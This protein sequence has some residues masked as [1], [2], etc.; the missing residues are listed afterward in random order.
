[1]ASTARDLMTA[2][3]ITVRG[4]APVLEVIHLF[5]EAQI[6]CVPVV[7]GHGNLLGLV[8]AADL[9]AALDQALD[10]DV[11]DGEE[12]DG[13]AGGNDTSARLARLTAIEAAN[14]EPTCV[15]PDTPLTDV[16]RIMRDERIHCV[17]VREG[18]KPVGVV[19]T[20]DLLVAGIR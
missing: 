4:D 15:V 18:A 10:Q 17:I 1:M 12:V 5:V 8:T 6:G 14:P 11:D 2:N 9:L 16:A 7:D 3:L 19:T 20:L 13:E